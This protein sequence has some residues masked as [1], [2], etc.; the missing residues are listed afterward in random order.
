MGF[1]YSV[2]SLLWL[3][4][5][6]VLITSCAQPAASAM[7]AKSDLER[8]S[9]PQVEAADLQELIAGNTAFAFDLYHQLEKGGGNLFYSPYSIS[10]A[11]AMTYA[12]ARG[13]TETQMANT[14]HFNSSQDRFHP[15]FN[16]LD[17]ELASRGESIEDKE[18][19]GFQLNIANSIWG[20]V[21][22]KFLPEFLDVLAKNYGAGLRLLDFATDPEKARQI[23]NKWVEDQTE[24]K[25]K[26][27]I[28]KGIIDSMTRLVLANAIYFNAEW[29]HQFQED[30]THEGIFYSLDGTEVGV[31]MMSQTET[32]RYA[33][34]EGYQVVELTYVGDEAAML[35]LL[36]KEGQFTDLERTLNAEKVREILTGLESRSVALV[37]PK[38]E[39]ESKFRLKEPLVELGM[40]SAFG[41]GAGADFSGMDGTRNLF[42]SEVL[43]K[44]FVSVDEA[45]TEAAAATAVV[46]KEMAM[47]E[48]DVEMRIDRPFIF[49][50]QDLETGTILFLGRVMNPIG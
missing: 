24:E 5:V 15:A 38:F 46:M 34:G 11:L 2:K 48:P 10:L 20:Q 17:L 36:P 32:F 45:G 40:P 19:V 12:G 9:S 43:H 14:L 23:I 27:L 25:I 6:S 7:E 28:P 21:E 8:A 29:R 3:L 4:I 18:G 42:I 30:N 1:L 35:I 50:I 37:M 33:Q 22:Y 26:D 39:Y 16:A 49:M 41:F 31:Q 44:A 47:M 13:E